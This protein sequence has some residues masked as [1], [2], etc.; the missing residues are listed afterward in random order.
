MTHT[1]KIRTLYTSLIATLLLTIVPHMAFAIL[2]II[3]F[4]G[5]LVI[6]YK[7]RGEGEDPLV[8]NHARYIT[9]TIWSGSTIML[10]TLIIGSAF[11]LS[12]GVDYTS[13]DPCIESMSANAGA[14]ATAGAA[15]IQAMTAPCMDNFLEDNM[16]LFATTMLI[17]AAPVM[18]FFFYRI[19]TGIKKFKNCELFDHPNKWV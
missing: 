17:I 11:M 15:E 9:S 4:I 8:D 10:I 3:A 6:G 7:W 1:Q 18:L 13:F 12:A 19:L 16:R 14:L 2:A 5:T